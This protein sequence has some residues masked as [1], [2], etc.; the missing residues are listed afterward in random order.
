[1][2]TKIDNNTYSALGTFAETFVR[3]I[4]IA[5]SGVMVLVAIIQIVVISFQNGKL[6]AQD[7]QK[8]AENWKRMIW[9]GVTIIL[10]LSAFAIY[11][12]INAMMKIS[13]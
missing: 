12:V 5:L 1:M 9:C 13:G 2:I 6:E 10:I 4:F 3:S 8:R 11:E 7:T